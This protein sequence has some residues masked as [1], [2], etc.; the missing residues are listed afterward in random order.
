MPVLML[1]DG[2]PQPHKD[3]RILVPNRDPLVSVDGRHFLPKVLRG[4]APVLPVDTD[5]IDF[6]RNPEVPILSGQLDALLR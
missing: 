6:M 2:V 1:V 4:C 3:C 5:Q